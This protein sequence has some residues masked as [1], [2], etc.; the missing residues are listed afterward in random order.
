MTFE[1]DK[2]LGQKLLQKAIYAGD[3]ELVETLFI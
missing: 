3:L 2:A 1:F